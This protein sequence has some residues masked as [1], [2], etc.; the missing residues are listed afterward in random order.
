MQHL[1]GNSPSLVTGLIFVIIRNYDNFAAGEHRGKFFL[2]PIPRQTGDQ[3]PEVPQ[4][5]GVF[6]P[7][8]NQP[9]FTR[10]RQFG[11]RA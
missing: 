9:C 1:G 4:D 10:G 8:H 2:Y 5:G 6:A 7:L 3:V 11:Y